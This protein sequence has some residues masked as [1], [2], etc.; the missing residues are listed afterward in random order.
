MADLA[1][2]QNALPR[3][4]IFASPM[5]DPFSFARFARIADGAF[6]GFFP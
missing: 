5:E 2:R 4:N 1:A 6:H 3:L